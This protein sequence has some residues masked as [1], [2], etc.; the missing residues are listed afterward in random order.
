M[1]RV[2]LVGSLLARPGQEFAFSKPCEVADRC[3]VA[4][5]CQN[6]VVGRRY[7]VVA[8]RPAKH[9]VCT[10]HE[11]GVQAVDVEEQP[12]YANVPTAQLRGTRINWKPVSCTQRGCPNW[13]NCFENGLASGQSYVVKDSGADVNCPMGYNLRFVRLADE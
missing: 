8:V 11:G 12:L 3:P 5:P 6:L 10:E 9:S 13:S 1:A 7:K 4:T 2:T